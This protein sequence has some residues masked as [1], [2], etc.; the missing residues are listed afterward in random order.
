MLPSRWLPEEIEMSPRIPL[1]VL[2]LAPVSEGQSG[3]E[4]IQTALDV[5]VQADQLGYRRIWFAQH[6][7]SPGVASAS[8]GV[9]VTLAA[10]RTTRIRVGSGAVLLASTPPVLAAEQF[11]TV[12]ALHPGR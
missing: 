1:S 8:P 4:A 10:D 11:G 9:L 3:A 6:H 5:A 2:E 7:L 12:A